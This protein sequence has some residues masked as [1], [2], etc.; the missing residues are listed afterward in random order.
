MMMQ[1]KYYYHKDYGSKRNKNGNA[2]LTG[3][4]VEYLTRNDD[5]INQAIINEISNARQMKLIAMIELK[6]IFS[7]TNGY[8]SLILS[9]ELCM[10]T[11]CVEM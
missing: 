10:R 1:L 3:G 11:L 7:K 8:F 9:T 4:M 5:S 6:G 2:S